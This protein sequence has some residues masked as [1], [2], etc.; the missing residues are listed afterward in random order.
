VEVDQRPFS[1]SPEEEVDEIFL[2]GVEVD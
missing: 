1:V 2:D